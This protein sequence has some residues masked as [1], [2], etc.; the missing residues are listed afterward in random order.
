MTLGQLEALQLG[1]W[2]LQS[3]SGP[4]SSWKGCGVRTG[5]H[6][7]WGLVFETLALQG[8]HAPKRA[9][10][11]HVISGGDLLKFCIEGAANIAGR[12]LCPAH[13]PPSEKV[14]GEGCAHLLNFHQSGSCWLSFLGA[15]P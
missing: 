12:M 7:G 10:S 8:P 2:G 6:Q 9:E 4:M 5:S 14:F 1:Q 3:P 15:S 13:N 11:G